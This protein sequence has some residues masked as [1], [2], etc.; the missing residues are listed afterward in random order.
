[1]PEVVFGQLWTLP[2][3]AF[4]SQGSVGAALASCF[5][6]RQGF[7]PSTEVVPSL[8]NVTQKQEATGRI[9]GGHL[10]LSAMFITPSV[11]ARRCRQTRPNSCCR[12]INPE[13][14]LAARGPNTLLGWAPFLPRARASGEEWECVRVRAIDTRG[15][16]PPSRGTLQEGSPKG[17]RAGGSAGG[18]CGARAAASAPSNCPVGHPSSFIHLWLLTGTCFPCENRFLLA[19][20]VDSFSTNCWISTLSIAN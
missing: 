11:F 3:R 7:L 6:H 9:T 13:P 10:L 1:M 20:P 12:Q 5:P 2:T 19:S 16:C 4:F 15:C 8:A 18:S 17:G 14:S